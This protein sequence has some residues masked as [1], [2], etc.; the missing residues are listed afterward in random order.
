MRR[1]SD[2]R[3]YQACKHLVLRNRYLAMALGG[4]VMVG[5]YDEKN[6]TVDLETQQFGLFDAYS[7]RWNHRHG[8]EEVVRWFR[9]EGFRE[10]TV[11]DPGTG[12]VR[13]RGQL[14]V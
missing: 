13:V 5:H 7:P 9:E 12:N 10:V 6:P 3:R 11:I 2:E 4:V 1:L 14:P 8:A